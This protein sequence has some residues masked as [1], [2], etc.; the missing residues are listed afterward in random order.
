[1]TQPIRLSIFMNEIMDEVNYC[2]NRASGTL[3][4]MIKKIKTRLTSTQDK[5]KG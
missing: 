4:T 5:G 1:M 3:L 2:T